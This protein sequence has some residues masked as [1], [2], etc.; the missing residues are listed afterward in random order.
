MVVGEK[1]ERANTRLAIRTSEGAN[2][3]T[4]DNPDYS[5]IAFVP[6]KHDPSHSL[7]HFESPHCPFRHPRRS[8]NFARS[9]KREPYRAAGVLFVDPG[10][11]SGSGLLADR[12]EHT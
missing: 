3:V 12:R 4:W 10:G 1:K 5:I 2:S 8:P 9:W 7:V 6:S 11:R